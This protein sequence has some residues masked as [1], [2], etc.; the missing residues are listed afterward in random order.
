MQIVIQ[1]GLGQNFKIRI[2]EIQIKSKVDST[3]LA[4]HLFQAIKNRIDN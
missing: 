3:Q 1:I 2:L 4:L